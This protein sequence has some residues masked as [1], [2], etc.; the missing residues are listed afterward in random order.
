MKKYVFKPYSKNFPKLFE[1]EKRRVV[2]CI[3]TKSISIEHVGSTAIPNMGGKGIMDITI[4]VIKENIELVSEQLQKLGYEFRPTASTPDRLFFRTNL[5]DREEGIRIYH[6]HLTYLRSKDW[7]E[8]LA[9]RNYLRSNLR[10]AKKYAAIKKKAAHLA[11][12]DR[13][14]YIKIKEP[15]IKGILEKLLKEHSLS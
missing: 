9:F 5:P 2:S 14:K 12:E 4:A 11:N 8:L 6:I 7:E 1:K 15:T 3:G 10:E 13:E